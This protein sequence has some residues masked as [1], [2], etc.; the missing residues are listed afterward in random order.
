[1]ADSWQESAADNRRG[2][3]D[4]SAKVRGKLRKGRP[5]QPG[6]AAEPGPAGRTQSQAG[7]GQGP[8]PDLGAVS[9]PAFRAA[10]KSRVCSTQPAHEKA[11]PIPLRL[12]HATA[13][14]APPQ[15]FW[16]TDRPQAAGQ[17]RKPLRSFTWEPTRPGPQR[18]VRADRRAP[19]ESL[20]EAAHRRQR[21]RGNAANNPA[22]LRARGFAVA[23]PCRNFS[24]LQ[25]ARHARSPEF[26]F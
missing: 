17:R 21:P 9:A 11:V 4:E 8:G 6:G 13:A 26:C 15:I 10:T 22:L 23:T 16:S 1:M 24:F 20:P 18:Q 2:A 5:R 3:A 19:G 14:A 7:A 12:F 25:G